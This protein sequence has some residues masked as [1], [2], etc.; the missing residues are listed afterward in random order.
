MHLLKGL[1]VVVA[2][3]TLSHNIVEQVLGK[4]HFRIIPPSR[5]VYLLHHISINLRD[6]V[7]V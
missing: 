3:D 6:V 5:I 1:C 4:V 2:S 7:G